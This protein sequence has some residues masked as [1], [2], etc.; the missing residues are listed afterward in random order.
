SSHPYGDLTLYEQ[1][2][3]TLEGDRVTLGATLSYRPL[4]W[5]RHR[6]TVGGDIGS[7]EANRYVP[8]QG[9]F[10]PVSL[11]QRTVGTPRNNVYWLDNLKLR[12]AWGQAG[13]APD[14]FAKDTTYGLVTT[15]DNTTGQ[16]V[17]AL[18]LQTVGNPNVKPERGS[19]VEAGFDAALL[20]NRLGLEVTYYHK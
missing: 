1:Y 16:V 9:L 20:G 12:L 5:L 6:L 4:R 15:V 2:V 8:P 18:Q 13:N 17:S 10:D 7:L 11:G 19:E 14:P 3:N